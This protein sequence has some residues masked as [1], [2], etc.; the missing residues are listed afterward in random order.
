[1]Q[2]FILTYNR[3]NYLIECLHS[4]LNQ[5]D[6][7][8]LDIKIII[9]DNST[10]DQTQNFF[11]TNLYP[12]V[13]YIR[14][15]PSLPVFDHFKT[16]LS[17]VQDELFMIFHDDDVML[18][19]MVS[20]LMKSIQE[21]SSLVAVGANAY[22]LNNKTSKNKFNNS[23]S[24][25]KVIDKRDE[26]LKPYLQKNSIIPFPSYMYRKK[27]TKI[28][29]KSDFGKYGDVYFLSK[30]LDYGSIMNLKEPI[31]NYRIHEGQDSFNS[32]FKS[33]L[34]LI[35]YI[36]NECGYS[37]KDNAVI[38]FRINSIYDEL[39][40]QLW[41]NTVVSYGRIYRFLV[42]SLKA[43]EFRTAFKMVYR[44]IQYKVRFL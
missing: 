23:I 8:D 21:D 28:N 14:R 33:K 12:G 32:D 5:N 34:I 20:T 13:T 29:I 3:L 4:V 37:K 6:F 36:I 11:K 26:L 38:S 30:C 43:K 1:M 41:T 44:T 2:I 24:Y 42:L 9:S 19:S 39:R 31:F 22:L 18:A 15:I 17:E 27:V 25:N 10:D 7:Q 16:V 40:T 35:N